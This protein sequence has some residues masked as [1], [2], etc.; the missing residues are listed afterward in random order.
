MEIAAGAIG[1][2]IFWLM[3]KQIQ[4]Q[5]RLRGQ[6]ETAANVAIFGLR[7]AREDLRFIR[8]AQEFTPDTAARLERLAESLEYYEDKATGATWR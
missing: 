1:L 2:L 3:L 7:E 5:A 4:N 8:D 6:A